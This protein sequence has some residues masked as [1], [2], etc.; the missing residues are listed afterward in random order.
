MA[1]H[2]GHLVVLQWL[3]ANGCDWDDYGGL[4]C[5][6][7][8]YGGH[9][10]VL[11]YAHANGC[12]LDGDMMTSQAAAKGGHL[13]TLQW[14]RA[15]GGDWDEETTSEAAGGGHLVALQWLRANGCPWDELTCFAAVVRGHLEVLQW[16][17]ANGCP[18]DSATRRQCLQVAQTP[19]VDQHGRL[20]VGRHLVAEWIRG[21][22]DVEA[23]VLQPIAEAVLVREYCN[24]NNCCPSE[25][26]QA[27]VAAE[28]QRHGLIRRDTS[29]RSAHSCSG[30]PYR[31]CPPLAHYVY[32]LGGRCIWVF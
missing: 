20:P 3:R 6:V 28:L 15:N 27:A 5:S 24:I 32:T 1:A 13:A 18:W 14:L 12:G 31:D 21:Q 22:V 4:I 10:A 9:L 29:F 30:F 19:I 2:G 11:Q 17:A 8:A 16:A 25:E 23:E 26:G 7:A